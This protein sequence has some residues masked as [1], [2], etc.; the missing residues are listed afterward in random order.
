[1]NSSKENYLTHDVT[2]HSEISDIIWMTQNRIAVGCENGVIY[3]IQI[4]NVPSTY[5]EIIEFQVSVIRFY[6]MELI[7]MPFT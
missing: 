5:E 1:M 3:V 4:Y 6:K 7:H 2:V